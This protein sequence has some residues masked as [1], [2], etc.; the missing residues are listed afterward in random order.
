MSKV[1]ECEVQWGA[2]HPTVLHTLE[3]GYIALQPYLDPRLLADSVRYERSPLTWPH[4]GL[5]ISVNAAQ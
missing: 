4:Q 2:E 1:Q 5:L 3:K